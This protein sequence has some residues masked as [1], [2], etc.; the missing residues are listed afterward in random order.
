[1]Q[2]ITAS[3]S[4]L[5]R[6]TKSLRSHMGTHTSMHTSAT[7]SALSHMPTLMLRLPLV[8]VLFDSSNRFRTRVVSITGL[9]RRVSASQHSPVSYFAVAP[10]CRLSTTRIS[11]ARSATPSTPRR[12]QHSSSL[13]RAKDHGPNYILNMAF[14]IESF[15]HAF[16][17]VEMSEVTGFERS[18]LV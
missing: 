6:Q 1:M 16:S 13:A 15:S 3:F 17:R 8:W 12:T 10:P 7:F 5:P 14:V 11:A 9:Q 2:N 18:A 4:D